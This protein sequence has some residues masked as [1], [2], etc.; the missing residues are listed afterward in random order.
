MYNVTDVTPS[1]KTLPSSFQFKTSSKI[2]S[3]SFVIQGTAGCYQLVS[4]ASRGSGFGNSSIDVNI[5]SS[6]VAP[7]AP[8]LSTAVFSDDGFKIV[9]TL[10]SYS[11][12]GATTISGYKGRFACSEV[13]SFLGASAASCIWTSAATLVA[14]LGSVSSISGAVE[15]GGIIALLPRKIKASCTSSQTCSYSVSNNVTLAAPASA[16]VPSVSIA[17][18]ASIGKCDDILLDPTG[19]TGQAGR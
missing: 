11:D 1:A 6:S 5:R 18:S 3:G 4:Y 2:L 7:S 13:V 12:R 8:V 17:T 19:S 14:T 16:V 9:M 10:D 15:V